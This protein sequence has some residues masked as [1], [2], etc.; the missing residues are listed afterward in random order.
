VVAPRITGIPEL[1]ADGV[2]GYLTTPGD[3]AELAERIDRLVRD[4]RLRGRFGAAG[5]R[6]VEEHFNQATEIARLAGIMAGRLQE[7]ARRA[8]PAPRPTVAR[9]AALGREAA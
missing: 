6:I 7:S 8:A 9:P 4:P 5:V 1:V 3:A 2:S